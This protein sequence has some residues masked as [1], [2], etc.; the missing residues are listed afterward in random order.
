MI[1]FIGHLTYVVNIYLFISTWSLGRQQLYLLP[2]SLDVR[3][4]LRLGEGEICARIEFSL[5]LFILKQEDIKS[6]YSHVVENY[7]KLLNDVKYVQTFKSLKLRYDQHQDRLK[8]RDRSALERWDPLL[9]ENQ[10]DDRNNN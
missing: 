2:I 1:F 3:V 8:D 10:C 7:G 4:K 6:L 5:F 9:T